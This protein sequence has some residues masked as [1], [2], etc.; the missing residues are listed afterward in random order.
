LVARDGHLTGELAGENCKGEEKLKRLSS[1]AALRGA[2]WGASYGYG[3]SAED[4][5]FLQALGH[6]TA[7]NP[8]R[9]LKQTASQLG[10]KIENWRS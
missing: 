8:D 3:N 7:V 10:W 1:E 9:K 5:P 4:I 2:D 6:P